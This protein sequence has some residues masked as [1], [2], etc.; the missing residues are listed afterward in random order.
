M[1]PNLI[2]RES[3][4]PLSTAALQGSLL[5]PHVYFGLTGTRARIKAPVQSADPFDQVHFS[6]CIVPFAATGILILAQPIKLSELHFQ[7][8]SAC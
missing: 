2:A 1:G 3:D 5:L 4:F 8:V 6:Y 7:R